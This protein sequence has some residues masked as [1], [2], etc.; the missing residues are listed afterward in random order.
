MIEAP[1]NVTPDNETI[2]IDKT[3][4]EHG[5]YINAFRESFTFNGDNLAW[6]RCEYYDNVTGEILGYSYAPREGIPWNGRYRNGD[7]VVINELVGND[8]YYNGNDYKYRFILYQADSNG[9]PLCDMLC[10]TGRVK[11]G[12]G[13]TLMIEKGVTDIDEPYVMGGYEIGYCM[14]QIVSD[15]NGD[16][17]NN[18]IKITAYNKQTGE[19][20]LNSAISGTVSEGDRYKVYRSFY[21]TPCYFVRCRDKAI[22]TPSIA[23][24]AMTGGVELSADWSIASE[25][26]VSLQKY[27]WELPNVGIK[28]KEIYSYHDKGALPTRNVS[29]ATLDAVMPILAN[30]R[31]T[32]KLTATTQDSYV[33]TQSVTL[34]DYIAMNDGIAESYSGERVESKYRVVYNDCLGFDK[35]LNRVNIRTIQ[36]GDYTD[37]RIWKKASGES[38]FKYVGTASKSGGYITGHDYMPDDGI[39]STYAISCKSGSTHYWKE[40]GSIV[41]D[42]KG[43]V[44]IHKLEGNGEYFGLTRYSI[45][46]SFV[47]DFEIGR[48]NININDG[49]SVINSG[50]YPIV[51]KESGRYLS[52]DFSGALTQL[53]I[54]GKGFTLKDDQSIFE[55]SLDF[56]DDGAYLLKLPERGPFIVKITGKSIR[57]NDAGASIIS[58]DFTQIEDT[59]RVIV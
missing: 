23:I 25:K 46:D 38:Y 40:L 56:Y 34:D 11:S 26:E 27:Q 21:K 58:F 7:T 24:N 33:Q 48:P 41:P 53:S 15:N 37:Y 9:S 54:N 30:K 4:D 47:M 36:S 31:I 39:Q 17:V 51:I 29:E 55:R 22:I 35:S 8:L 14:L 59:A 45:S 3:K 1:I 19:L 12:S 5:E 2:Y 50:S 16:K 57:Q 49:Q 42:Y 10:V 43:R 44:V 6:W 32:A 18:K 52:G 20:T 28:G 13:S